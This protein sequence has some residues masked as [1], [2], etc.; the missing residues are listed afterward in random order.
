MIRLPSKI[1]SCLGGY[2][3]HVGERDANLSWHVIC[4]YLLPTIM[5]S[6]QADNVE[7][8]PETGSS[9][10]GERIL[11]P[12]D[13]LAIASFLGIVMIITWQAAR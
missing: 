4:T 3:R 13:W 8:Q 5:P 6:R 1:V 10:S 2:D 12:N 11:S 7:L 9:G